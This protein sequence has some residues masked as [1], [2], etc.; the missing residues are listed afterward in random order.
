MTR[1][2]YKGFTQ[3]LPR[4]LTQPGQLGP[5]ETARK[6]GEDKLIFRELILQSVTVVMS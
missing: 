3:K 5:T 4:N 6:I 2:G 1:I